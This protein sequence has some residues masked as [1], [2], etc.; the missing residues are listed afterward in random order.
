[1]KQH[2]H[3]FGASGS[4]TTTI[5]KALCRKLGYNHFDSDDYFWMPTDDPFTLERP[6]PERLRLLTDDLLSCDKWILSGSL[7]G[8][9]DS[10][11]PY[12]DLTVFVYVPQ[13][14]R[15]E[16]LRKREYERYGDRMLPGGE[17]HD[18][19][20]KFLDWAAAY[21]AGTSYGRS[22]SKHEAWL[23]RIECPVL[24]I[25]ND[26]LEDS[27]DSVFKAVRGGINFR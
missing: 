19:T 6:V 14:I 27:V 25:I 8:W 23:E 17:K 5:A 9:G 15:L 24:R 4:G 22:L 16:R 13:D 18:H 26:V 3:I 2:I 21:D 7:V 11:I 1:M 20:E 10:L 12:F